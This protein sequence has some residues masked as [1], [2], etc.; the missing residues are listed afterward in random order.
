MC[1][2]T[3]PETDL[4]FIGVV[5]N[6]L[7]KISFT[8]DWWIV[9]GDMVGPGFLVI[10]VHWSARASTLDLAI[11]SALA[12]IEYALPDEDL[13]ITFNR[14]VKRLSLSPTKVRLI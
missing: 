14:A 2:Y 11:R 3:G 10:T 5:K 9:G 7:G 8:C 1:L 4:A 12:A 13:R 6:S